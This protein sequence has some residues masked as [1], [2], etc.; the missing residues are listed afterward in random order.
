MYNV[1]SNNLNLKMTKMESELRSVV[2]LFVAMCV[3][4]Q[5][6]QPTLSF[7]LAFS[8]FSE[9]KVKEKPG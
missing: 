8:F 6:N 5:P 2:Y 1:G 3:P 7:N 9:N 4:T